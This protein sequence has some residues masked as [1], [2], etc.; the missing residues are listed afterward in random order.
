MISFCFTVIGYY[1]T[2]YSDQLL[3][4]SDRFLL[5]LTVTV[6]VI[7]YC[8]RNQLLLQWSVSVL[9]LTVTMLQWSV[10]MLQWPVSVLQLTVTVTGYCV[11]VALFWCIPIQM[12]LYCAERDC[13]FALDLMGLQFLDIKLVHS[14]LMGIIVFAWERSESHETCQEHVC[15]YPKNLDH[16]EHEGYFSDNYVFFFHCDFVF[17]T[18]T[19]TPN[20]YYHNEAKCYWCEENKM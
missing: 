7:G 18:N 1:F 2:C 11:T 5:Q 13:G 9:Q 3:C 4:Y 6:T 19:F 15:L 20:P 12:I 17:V 16:E 14:Y 8:Y 10:T